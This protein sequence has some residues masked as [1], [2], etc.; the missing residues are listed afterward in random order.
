MPE[1]THISYLLRIWRAHPRSPWHAMLVDVARPGEHQHFATLDALFA[2]LTAQT[3][4]APPV[5]E[6][7]SVLIDRDFDHYTPGDVS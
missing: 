2:F 1:L 4:Q 5:P 7:M 3:S 6:Q